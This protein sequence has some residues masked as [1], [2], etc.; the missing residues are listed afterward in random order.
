MQRS[1]DSSSQLVMQKREPAA[2]Y[3]INNNRMKRKVFSTCSRSSSKKEMPMQS[4]LCKVKLP[5]AK[6][7]FNIS[8]VLTHITKTKYYYFTWSWQH[9]MKIQ[10]LTTTKTYIAQ[11]NN[12]SVKITSWRRVNKSLNHSRAIRSWFKNWWL[13]SNIPQVA[14]NCII[15]KITLLLWKCVFYDVTIMNRCIKTAAFDK[16]ITA[17]KKKINL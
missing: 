10:T 15:K 9:L 3:H 16:K 6:L 1:K 5:N 11:P 4:F 17:A 8:K 2:W 12:V 13:D 14:I 7:I